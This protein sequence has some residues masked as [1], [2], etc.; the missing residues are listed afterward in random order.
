M[1]LAVAL[2]RPEPVALAAPML[3]ALVLGLGRAPRAVITATAALDGERRVEG[4]ESILSLELSSASAPASVAVEVALPS[5]LRT[6]TASFQVAL[7]PGVTR[8][9]EVR[10]I[11]ARWG[12]QRIGPIQVTIRDPLGLVSRRFELAHRLKVRVY[13][14]SETLRTLLRPRHTQAQAGNLV[15]PLRGEGIE[16]AD[17]R[18]FLP[19]DRVRRINWRASARRDSLQVNVQHPERS[20]DVVIFLDSF[21]E[22]RDQDSSTLDL[23]VRAAASLASQLLARRDRVGLIGFGG[24]LRWLVPGAGTRQLYKILDSLLDTDVL[25]S[26]A[27]KG[28]EV[29][30]PRTLPARSQVIALTPLLDGRTLSV[31]S[32]IG[33]RGHDLAI[34]EISPVSF[35]TEPAD[36]VGRLAWRLWRLRREGLRYRFQSLGVPVVTWNAGAPLEAALREVEAFRRY[37]RAARA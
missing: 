19:G 1:L 31:L 13:P 18:P 36:G 33:G 5:G 4:G 22:V 6:K 32:D 20:A 11:C 30:P 26:D 28:L 34:I 2:G 12:V 21:V 24:T 15:S 9:L 29:L 16:F 8:H 7:A 35:R 10:L 14:R 3:A 17:I 27:W 37:A 25:P 23:G